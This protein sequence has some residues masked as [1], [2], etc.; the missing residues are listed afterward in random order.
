MSRAR[1]AA[2]TFGV[3]DAGA[4]DDDAITTR[5]RT[6]VRAD[7]VAAAQRAGA[8]DGREATLD[9]RRGEPQHAGPQRGPAHRNP[10]RLVLDGG[11]A[12]R[13]DQDCRA[14][15]SGRA[16]EGVAEAAQART[17]VGTAV[18]RSGSVASAARLGSALRLSD[19]DR[20]GW[21]PD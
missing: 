9:G 12:G 15:R 16:A 17:D 1:L 7:A 21:P 18:A 20:R 8:I 6:T 11:A 2:C 19:A 4:E 13:A 5:N 14:R 3:R 10:G